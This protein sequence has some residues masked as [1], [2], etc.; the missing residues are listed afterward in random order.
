MDSRGSFHFRIIYSEWAHLN[1]ENARYFLKVELVKNI[2][3]RH[4]IQVC[5]QSLTFCIIL[6][7]CFLL[8]G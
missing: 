8:L 4:V 3:N 1:S 5:F 6:A 7:A 2:L